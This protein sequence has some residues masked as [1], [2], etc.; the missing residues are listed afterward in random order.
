MVATVARFALCSAWMLAQTAAFASD[1]PPVGKT[2][3]EAEARLAFEQGLEELRGERWPEAET[4]FRRSLGFVKRMSTM[5]DLAF[6]LYMRGQPRE[7]LALLEELGR[8]EDGV[9][10]TRYEGYA[11]LLMPRVLAQLGTLQFVVS[12]P[13][14]EVR[15][16]GELAHANGTTRSLLVLPGNHDVAV[17]APGFEP[18]Y[19]AL[20]ARGGVEL[21]RELSLGSVESGR[22]PTPTPELAEA[23]APR[24]H[25]F[26]DVAPWVV[27]GVG[28]ALLASGVV[29]GI[30]ALNADGEFHS[31]CPSNRDCNPADEPVRNR[32]VAFGHAADV[33]LVSGAVVAAG[34]ITWR[35][36][37]PGPRQGSRSG[38][39]FLSASGNF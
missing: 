16:D 4:D 27:V 23:H 36:L 39:V 6:V 19:F 8:G 28:G 14:A 7:C 26:L 37:T 35:L 3:P 15:I 1:P 38:A 24:S 32:A 31:R 10:D 18:K 2:T 25:A 17:T 5:Y 33:L 20:V 13:F 22:S 29:T 12:P 34:G 11:A 30:A 9:H 21:Q